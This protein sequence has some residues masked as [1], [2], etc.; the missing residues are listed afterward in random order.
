VF[1][2]PVPNVFRWLIPIM[3]GAETRKVPVG[4]KSHAV[5]WLAVSSPTS[6]VVDGEFFNGPPA[7]ALRL[8]TGP[9]FTYIRR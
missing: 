8:E 2:Y 5:N 7:E 6:W 9:V 3:Y 1:P 4:A